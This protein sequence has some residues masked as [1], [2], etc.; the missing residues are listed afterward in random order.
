MF[1]AMNGEEGEARLPDLE[2]RFRLHVEKG[3]YGHKGKGIALVYLLT[4]LL[5]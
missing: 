1:K 3:V 2:Q 4:A 5:T